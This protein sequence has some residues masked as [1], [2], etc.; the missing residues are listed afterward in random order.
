ML[1]ARILTNVSGVNAFDYATEHSGFE[2]TAFD[3]YFQ[4]VDKARRPE[5]CGLDM[6]LRYMTASGAT[7]SVEF[8]SINAAKVVTRAASK[9][10]VE[11]SSIWKVSLLSTDPIKGTINLKVTLTEGAA[12]KIVY[13]PAALLLD[14]GQDVC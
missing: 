8:L 6:P 10:F 11:D 12:V 4:F 13:L 5:G 3:V 1:S 2:G 7:V 14:G 9:P